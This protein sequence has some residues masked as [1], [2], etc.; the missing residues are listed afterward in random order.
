MII[1]RNNYSGIIALYENN[2][3]RDDNAILI[4]LDIINTANKRNK[5]RPIREGDFVII[6]CCDP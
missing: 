1:T 5:N 3:K 4:E 6:I 2:F